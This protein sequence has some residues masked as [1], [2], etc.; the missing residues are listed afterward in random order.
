M[1]GTFLVVQVAK[2]LSFQSKGISSIPGPGTN[3]PHGIAKK[4]LNIFKRE[5]KEVLRL[6]VLSVCM[7]ILKLIFKL[8]NFRSY[9]PTYYYTLYSGGVTI[10]MFI[11]NQHYIFKV[12][13]Y[14]G[15]FKKANIITLQINEVTR[16][17][18]SL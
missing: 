10:H 1:L 2:A 18:M 6:W 5:G 17:I 15:T 8:G 12:D 11:R 9:H 14:F 3:I 16:A 4:F 7:F 13:N